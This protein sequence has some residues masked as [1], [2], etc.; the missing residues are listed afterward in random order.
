MIDNAQIDMVSFR[1]NEIPR[2]ISNESMEL[3]AEALDIED[4]D[5]TK[6]QLEL[7]FNKQDDSL[8]IQCWINA[9]ATL[10]CDRS[11]DRYEARLE[12]NYEVVFQLDVE[13]EREELSGTL[14][15]L[16]PSRNIINITRELRDT[17]LL[18][19]PVKKIH[20]RYIKE[21]EITGFSASFGKESKDD[22]HDPRW[23]ALTELKQKIQKN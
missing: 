18:S 20:P 22:V 17:V 21:G 11:L 9:L 7:R 6:V 13:D 10:T 16:D 4:S 5:I 23:D 8:R 19:I 1:F 2:G 12:S 15:R 14:R 3:S